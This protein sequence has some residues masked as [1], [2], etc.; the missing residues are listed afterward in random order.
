MLK[1]K[2]WIGLTIVA[3]LAAATIIFVHL[4]PQ[5]PLPPLAATDTLTPAS[6]RYEKD[7]LR[8]HTKHYNTK[9]SYPQYQHPQLPPLRPRRFNPNTADSIL[10]LEQGLKTWQVSNMLK[11]RRAGGRWRRRSDMKRLYGLSEEQYSQLRP[12]IDLPDTLPSDTARRDTLLRYVS[13]KRDT[14][15][16]LNTADTAQLQLLRGIGRWTA[17]Q[18]VRYREQLG[19]YYSVEQLREIPHI[20][21]QM[22]DTVLQHFTLDTTRITPLR[23]NRCAVGTL[24]HHPYLRFEQARAIYEHRR[25]HIRL[26]GLDDLRSLPELT[27]DDLLRLRPYLSFE[28]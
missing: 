10:L 8:R 5:R 11:Y 19:G 22:L 4:V 13:H 18:I 17:M 24:S 28:K 26:S 7:T 3:V 20:D 27:Q 6:Q 1:P 2:Q 23:V 12:Y 15:L 25:Q 9:R 14:I 16:E 21:Q